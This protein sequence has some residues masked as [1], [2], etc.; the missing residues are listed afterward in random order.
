MCNE[1]HTFG[2]RKP[3]GHRDQQAAAPSVL[4]VNRH[5]CPEDSFLANTPV[6]DSHDSCY[7]YLNAKP[8]HIRLKYVAT[9]QQIDVR[10][11]KNAKGYVLFAAVCMAQ[12]LR[13][14]TT[15]ILVC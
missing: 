4:V 6:Y 5:R 13:N 11:A 7:Y 8:K 2:D 15:E 14:A 10:E 1:R 3:E 9:E 12:S